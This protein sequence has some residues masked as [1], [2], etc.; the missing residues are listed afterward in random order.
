ME[1][2]SVQ[3][4][5]LKLFRKKF[6]LEGYIAASVEGLRIATAA[7]SQVWH[8]GQEGRWD[9]DQDRGTIILRFADGVTATAPVQIVGTYDSS[10]SSFLWGWDH[11]YVAAQLQKHSV[12]VKAFGEKHGAKEL[13]TR[14]IRCTPQRAW[15][16]TA[17]AMRLAQANGAYRG[18][19]SPGKYAYFTFGEI[20][21]ER[22]SAQDTISGA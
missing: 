13:T 2:N 7:H 8:F 5:M 4:D 19:T 14:K 12:E 16:L 21:L 17:L 3:R 20:R 11:P 1:R 18:E 22:T 15:E 6:D 10:D 9:V